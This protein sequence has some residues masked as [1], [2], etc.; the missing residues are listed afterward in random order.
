MPPSTSDVVRIRL[1]TQQAEDLEPWVQRA[2]A[3]EG[4]ILFVATVAPVWQQGATIW[5][6]QA[7]VISGR[8]GHRI[9]K[10]VRSNVA[11]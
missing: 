6:L 9:L 11:R 2:A 5:E 1:T 4:N 7:V 8:I 10:L 3:D